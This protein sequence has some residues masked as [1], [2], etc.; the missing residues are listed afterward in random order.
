MDSLKSKLL[1]HIYIQEINSY[2]ARRKQEVDRGRATPE[3]AALLVQE[4]GYGLVKALELF[5]EAENCHIA[6]TNFTVHVDAAVASIDPGWQESAK[7]RWEAK[8]VGLEL[9]LKE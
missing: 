4:Y 2:A 6:F 1:E 7:R 8:R 9:I 5:S 3:L